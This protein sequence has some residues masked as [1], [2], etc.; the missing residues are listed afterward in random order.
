MPVLDGLRIRGNVMHDAGGH[1][2]LNT[3]TFLPKLIAQAKAQGYMFTTLSARCIPQ[4]SDHR[5]TSGPHWWTE[6]HCLS[7][8][9]R[10]VTFHESVWWLVM[11]I[12]VAVTHLTRPST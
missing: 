4:T 5:R 2:R 8:Q 3:E 11:L 9:I 6:P 7:R 1:T 12:F 10:Y